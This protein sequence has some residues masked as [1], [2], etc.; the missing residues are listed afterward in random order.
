[1]RIA[2]FGFKHIVVPAAAAAATGGMSAIPAVLAASVGPGHA[3]KDKP[4][5]E[6]SSEKAQSEESWFK[7]KEEEHAFNVRTFRE[8]FSKLLED[9][10]IKTLVVLIDDLDRCSPERVIE[11]L[12]AIK[13]FLSVPSTAFV[14]GADPRIVEHAIRLR[15]AERAGGDE[16]EENKRLVKDYL[17]K[18]IQIPYRLPRLSS[19]EIETYMSLLFCGLYLGKDDADRCIVQSHK[20]RTANRYSAFGFAKVKETL[21]KEPNGS[22]SESL[23]FSATA[24]PLIAKGLEGNPRQVKRFLNA[25]ILR[26]KLAKVAKLSH[27][28]DDVLVKLMI[29]EYTD[30]GLFKDLFAKQASQ[31]GL[32]GELAALEKAGSDESAFNEAAKDLIKG[33]R[34]KATRQWIALEP[35]LAHVDLRD[36]FWIARDKL[37]ATFAGLSMV[38]PLTRAVLADLLSGVT[39]QRNAGL[40]T[41]KQLSGDE[42]K[43]LY[44]LLDQAIMRQPD[45]KKGFDAIRLL[46]EKGIAGAGEQYNGIL[47]KVPFSRAN[48]AAGTDVGNLVNAHSEF[49]LVLQPALDRLKESNE[50]IGAAYR[51]TLK[52]GKK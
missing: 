23:I 37:D 46:M 6:G 1:M 17:E 27:I 50:K 4:T 18:V 41:A 5:H 21:G 10:D 48:I 33:W 31:A 40:E 34:D 25:F 51:T 35:A 11:N 38:S 20:E 29:L 39:V 45:D 3:A 52:G 12:E 13:L 42:F 24:A 47:L 9:S 16:P 49:R 8:R 36:Y 19:S 28:K 14:I 22:L 26:K 15:Y 43:M 32:P 2:K 30:D 7:A 44:E